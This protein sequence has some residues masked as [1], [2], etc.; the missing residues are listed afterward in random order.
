MRTSKD[1]HRPVCRAARERGSVYI[2]VL[3]ASLLV[4]AIGVS[5]LMAARVQRRAVS[6][7][8]DRIQARELARAGIDHMMWAVKDDATGA[9]WRTD[10]Q[11]GDYLDMTFAGGT[12]SVS[13][14]D[15][16]D[17]I[18]TDDKADP[19]ELTSIGVFGGAKYIL[20]VTINSDGSPQAGT[21]TRVVQ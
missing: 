18:L 17:G 10:L 9:A 13:G 15:P 14:A 19:V 7:T 1:G 20:S 2:L 16:V 11:N 4:A 3:G 5:S 6:V 12:F 21:W 8:A